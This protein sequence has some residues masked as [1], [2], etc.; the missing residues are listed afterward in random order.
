MRYLLLSD[1][2]ANLTA[3]DAALDAVKGRW[4]RIYCLGD[5]VDYGPDPNE[6]AERVKALSPIIIR[7]NH[8]K[9][10]AGLTDLHDFNPLPNSQRRGRA[11]KCG[12]RIWNTSSGCLPGRFPRTALRWFTGPL[13]M[14]MNTFSSRD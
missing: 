10:V 8:D 1:I 4:E 9:A 6:V 13:R 7:G 11:S 2:H 5:I 14:R 12:P 3:L